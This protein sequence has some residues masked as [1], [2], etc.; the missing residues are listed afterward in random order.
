L[1]EPCAR[2]CLPWLGCLGYLAPIEFTPG[3]GD[4]KKQGIG[5]A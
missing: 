2:L 5:N 1:L 4:V 3:S